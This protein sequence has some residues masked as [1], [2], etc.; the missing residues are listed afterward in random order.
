V[1]C[2]CQSSI[3]ESIYL[4]KLKYMKNLKHIKAILGRAEVC[5]VNHLYEYD[6]WHFDTWKSYRGRRR[7]RCT[8]STSSSPIDSDC[9]IQ[10]RRQWRH[11]P[12]TVCTS[13]H[14]SQSRHL[15][16]H[17]TLS[18][19]TTQTVTASL[20]SLPT[21]RQTIIL[22]GENSCEITVTKQTH[23][24]TLHLYKVHP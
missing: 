5:R 7:L 2:V 4:S 11:L 12:A 19:D 9:C 20:R 10:P 22:Y 15:T 13:S 6:S 24:I 8:D 1:F 17:C 3:K 23:S 18:A 14:N 21:F 16:L